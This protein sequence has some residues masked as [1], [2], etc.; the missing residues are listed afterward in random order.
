MGLCFKNARPE[1]LLDPAKGAWEAAKVYAPPLG[2]RAVAEGVAA[3]K[4]ADFLTKLSILSSYRAF[5]PLVGEA[6]TAA[7][8]ALAREWVSSSGWVR[9]KEGKAKVGALCLHIYMYICLV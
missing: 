7:A 9:G 6:P 4:D 8:A 3:P 2:P 1:V 5:Y